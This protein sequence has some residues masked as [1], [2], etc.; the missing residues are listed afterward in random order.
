MLFGNR[1]K[2]IASK[3][4]SSVLSFLEFFY[5]QLKLHPS[6]GQIVMVFFASLN[7]TFEF[8]EKIRNVIKIVGRPSV[9]KI[10]EICKQ[11]FFSELLKKIKQF[12]PLSQLVNLLQINILKTVI[13]VGAS[14]R[15]LQLHLHQ[16]FLARNFYLHF[17][18]ICCLVWFWT[19]IFSS[20]GA[21]IITQVFK[22]LNLVLLFSCY[23][24]IIFYYLW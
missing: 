1:P 17:S 24:L 23:S 3:P 5:K 6:E 4:I 11:N 15:L 2:Y 22:A 10:M 18:G 19:E 7:Y 16:E 20:K 13:P 14:K 21:T 8:Q 12:F 9:S